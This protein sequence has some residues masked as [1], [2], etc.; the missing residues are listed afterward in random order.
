MIFGANQE[1]NV[2]TRKLDLNRLVATT[3]KV[4][5]ESVVAVTVLNSPAV[6][7][8]KEAAADATGPEMEKS[9][10]ACRLEGN[11]R[12]G[13]MQPKIPI[14]GSGSGIGRPSLI[15]FFFAAILC[16]NS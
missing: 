16:A 2:P 3:G 1:V 10:K 13:L 5:N 8:T 7:H 12:R 4:N 14:L 11:D 9:S 15:L 6:R